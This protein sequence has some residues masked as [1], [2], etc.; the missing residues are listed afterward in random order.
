MKH[1]I[2]PV[3]ATNSTYLNDPD[4]QRLRRDH[5]TTPQL[6]HGTILT[7]LFLDLD[8]SILG[9]PE[10]E[11]DAYSRDIR[12]EY[13]HYPWDAYRTGR[14]AI[15]NNFLTRDSLFFTEH[16]HYRYEIRAHNNINKEIRS[17]NQSRT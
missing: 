7:A 13:I 10:D 9:A 2:L 16:F 14:T 12:R 8:L 11:Y 17:L 4:V 1:T 3:F 5:T 6:L 15:L